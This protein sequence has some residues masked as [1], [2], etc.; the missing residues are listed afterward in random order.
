MD[1]IYS[2]IED[3]KKK[4]TYWFPLSEI[5]ILGH[6]RAIHLNLIIE[7]FKVI[8]VGHVLVVKKMWWCISVAV[9][10]LYT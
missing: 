2:T 5:L 4:T 1:V 8:I 3:S 7:L 9:L 6:R 10:N